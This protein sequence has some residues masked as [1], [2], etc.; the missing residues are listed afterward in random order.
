MTISVSYKAMNFMQKLDLKQG[1]TTGKTQKTILACRG[2]ESSAPTAGIEPA[3]L[4][5][6]MFD[7]NLGLK[8]ECS[9]TELRGRIANRQF[10]SRF[11]QRRAILPT[12]ET[13]APEY[14]VA[15]PRPSASVRAFKARLLYTTARFTHCAR[16]PPAAQAPSAACS[17]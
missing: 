12:A 7:S 6:P 8:V 4:R 14:A 15:F 13:N 11:V 10:I 9:T 2:P 17:L 5:S 16:T 3:A 1:K